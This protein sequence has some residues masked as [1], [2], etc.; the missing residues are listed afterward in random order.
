MYDVGFTGLHIQ[1]FCVSVSLITHHSAT[2]HSSGC[3]IVNDAVSH[4][5]ANVVFVTFSGGKISIFATI[6]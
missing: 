2:S 4:V 5:T 6:S 3:V 1:S